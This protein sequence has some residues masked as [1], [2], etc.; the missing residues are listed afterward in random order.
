[1]ADFIPVTPGSGRNV[2]TL[3]VTMPDSSS[4]DA[5]V[6]VLGLVSGGN[7][8]AI[9][10]GNP[11]PITVVNGSIAVTQSGSWS[12]AVGAA[13][14]AGTNVI[15]HVIVDSA[16]TT[17]VT[18]TVGVVGTFWQA[19]QP[20]SLASL[21][22]LAAGS[23]VIGHVIV[24]AAPTTAVTGTFWQSIQ[25]VTQTPATSGG[26]SVYSVISSGAANQDA[27]AIKSGAGQIYG[28]ALFNTTASAR[29][30]KLYNAASPTSASTPFLRIYLPPS[31]G[32]NVSMPDGLACG[33]AIGLR[34]TTGSPDND[35]GACSTGDVLVNVWWK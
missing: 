18:G 8:V 26:D 25:P 12:V 33:T 9:A 3:P 35:T 19:T 34:I 31:G 2:A 5:P 13:L 17:T 1:M 23:A 29:Y 11:L 16:P 30:V 27:A 28:W 32:S 4:A 20:V 14:P 7:W 6:G 10:T 15:G 24:D 22:A 21:P